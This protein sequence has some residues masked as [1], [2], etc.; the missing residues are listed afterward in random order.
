ML[1]HVS[2][3]LL[4]EVIKSYHFI[5]LNRKK[6]MKTQEELKLRNVARNHC[7]EEPASHWTELELS[8]KLT[9]GLSFCN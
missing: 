7:G 9:L 1:S 8:R 5:L 4:S 6:C 3:R 2:V